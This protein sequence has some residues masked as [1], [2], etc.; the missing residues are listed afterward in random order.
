MKMSQKDLQYS[1]N[2][3]KRKEK[4]HGDLFKKFARQIDR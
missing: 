4:T 1:S 2:K 3:K